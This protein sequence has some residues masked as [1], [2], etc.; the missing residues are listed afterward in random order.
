VDADHIFDTLNGIKW[1]MY[2]A[3]VVGKIYMFVSSDVA[4]S[5]GTKLLSGYGLANSAVLSIAPAVSQD[6]ADRIGEKN[7][8][9]SLQ[10]YKMD[11]C[12]II[13]VPEKRMVT[14]VILND[15]ISVGQEEGG[16]SPASGVSGFGNIK[17]LAVPEAAAFVA[18]RHLVS[19]ITVPSGSVGVVDIKGKLEGLNGN[20]YGGAMVQN[21][22]TDQSGDWFKSMNRIKH[23]CGVFN[24]YTHTLFSVTD[25]LVA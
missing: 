4:A 8:E 9:V 7:L 18:V 22:G 1:K 16:W 23:G 24:N 5:I 17:V 10:V 25:A 14:K 2:D 3:G 6:V 19:N 15:G 13:P 12:Y 11:N 21:I 20:Y